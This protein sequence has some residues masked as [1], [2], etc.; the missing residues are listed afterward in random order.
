MLWKETC[1]FVFVFFLMIF[2]LLTNNF[3][4]LW[5]SSCTKHVIKTYLKSNYFIVKIKKISKR[6]F[7]AASVSLPG[8]LS[9]R[10]PD[11][12]HLMFYVPD[13]IPFTS[14]KKQ[15]AVMKLKDMV[16]WNTRVSALYALGIWTM[17]S[18]YAYYRYTGQYDE[19][20]P[21]EERSSRPE[22]TAQGA[23]W[24]LR[25]TF[26]LSSASPVDSASFNKY[27]K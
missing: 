2:F 26:W 6:K 14:D 18:S 4:H 16:K 8:Q 5:I 7:F 21:G 23:R 1:F 20:L 22:H 19:T 24:M 12:V 10:R 9:W 3:S 11:C 15:S 27:Q 17:I 25:Y 13:V